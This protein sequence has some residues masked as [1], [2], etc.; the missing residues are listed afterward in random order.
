MDAPLVPPPPPPEPP[1][2]ATVLRQAYVNLCRTRFPE[3]MVDL[4]TLF[5][6]AK[7]ERS[8]LT[9]DEFRKEIEALESKRSLDLH[10][11]PDPRNVPEADKGIRRGNKLY[12][13]IYWSP[14]P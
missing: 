11:P 6:E 8:G 14:R 4:P 9:V 13:S 1:T 10:L 3:G 7:R 5:Y 12:Y 2:L